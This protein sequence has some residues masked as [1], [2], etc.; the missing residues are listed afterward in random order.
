MLHEYAL[1][2]LKQAGIAPQGGLRKS[3]GKG[4]IRKGWIQPSE[5]YNE[6][7]ERYVPRTGEADNDFG[8][9]LR[10]GSRI[11][12]R[13]F[14]DGDVANIGYGRESVTPAV[15][16]LMRIADG[17]VRR[18]AYELDQYT[19]DMREQD[20]DE[21]WDEDYDW[22]DEESDVLDRIKSI[23]EYEAL[24]E[25][26]A[27]AL[28]M[29]CIEVNNNPFMAKSALRRKTRKSKVK[30]SSRITDKDF[31][32]QC[33]GIRD[34]DTDVLSDEQGLLIFTDYNEAHEV[35]RSGKIPNAHDV[36][37]VLIYRKP[38]PKPFIIIPNNTFYIL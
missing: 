31:E 37:V 20:E 1:K 18:V 4:R 26:L 11:I 24:L 10:C 22:E 35:L 9:I 3:V 2:K 12:Y 17:D 5:L 28:E 29:Y 32:G 25:D 14:N 8:E 19:R 27:N 16:K 34:Y 15:Q 30:K 6:M 38:I 33:W 13:F 36:G 7:F 23:G 21:E